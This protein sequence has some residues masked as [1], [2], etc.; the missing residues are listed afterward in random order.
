MNL[1]NILSVSAALSAAFFMAS[2]PSSAQWQVPLGDIPIGRGA[3]TGFNSTPGAGVNFNTL[4]SQ[5]SNYPIAPT[6]CSKTVQA[7]TG[8]TGQFT[9]TLPSISGFAATCTVTIV[10][11]DTS[12]GKKLSGFPTTMTASSMLWPGQ[13]VTVEIVNGAWAAPQNPGR[14]KVPNGTTFYLDKVNGLDTNDCLATGAGRACQSF[15]GLVRVNMKDQFD[16]SGVSAEPNGTAIIQLANNATGGGGNTTTCSP[17]CYSLLHLATSFV[18]WE[19]SASLVIQGNAG[20]PS[21]TVVEDST[22]SNIGAY[23]F[24]GLALQNFQVHPGGACGTQIGIESSLQASVKLLGGMILGC[25]TSSQM[26]ANRHGRIAANAGTIS[27]GGNGQQL[28]I[29]SENSAIDLSSAT[30]SFLANTTYSAQT[31]NVGM[32]SLININPT[33]WTLN[34]HTITGQRWFATQGSVISTGTGTPNSTIPG[35]SNG[36]G[37]SGAVTD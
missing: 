31:L 9:I 6:D 11:G 4:N 35:N 20:D 36:T 21:L 7:G 26:N 3:G 17:N 30:V 33:T 37:A 27:V 32:Q 10:N 12:A 29:V 34:A 1:R 22:G 19:G 14:W 24:I 5:T 25:T 28:A 8:S 2:G 13:S 18:G 15:N 16:F 23:G